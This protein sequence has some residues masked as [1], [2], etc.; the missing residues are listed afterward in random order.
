MESEAE[1]QLTYTDSNKPQP[2]TLTV[3]FLHNKCV[4]LFSSVLPTLELDHF[5]LYYVQE[6]NR[7]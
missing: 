5:V 4:V 2:E 3:S 1:P 7:S 6:I